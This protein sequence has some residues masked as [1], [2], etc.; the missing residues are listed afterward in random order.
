MKISITIMAHPKRTAQAKA[1]F[2]RLYQYS[3][4]DVSITWDEQNDEWHTGRRSLMAGVNAKSDY[5]V[6]LQD[7]AIINEHFFTNLVKAI[8]NAP[9]RTVLSLYTGTTRPFAARV[10]AAVKKAQNGTYLQGYTLFWGVG[11]VIPTDHILPMLEFADNETDPYDTRIGLFYFRNMMPVLYTNP[12]LVDH[13][14]DLAGLVNHE[15]LVM[16]RR[17]AHRFIDADC[18]WT[19]SIT[20]I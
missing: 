17:V 10:A 19:A 9:V 4:S 16:G 8:E 11:I 18:D 15:G 20:E 6:V 12:S 3:F 7:D 14:D 13:D 2:D 1:L 5:H